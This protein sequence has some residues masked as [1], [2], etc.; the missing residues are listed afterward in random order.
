LAQSG[1]SLSAPVGEKGSSISRDQTPA[2]SAIARLGLVVE[3]SVPFSLIFPGVSMSM[4]EHHNATVIE[5]LDA[6]LL[7][8]LM[9]A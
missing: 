9:L 8:L 6:S 1:Y 7:S 4:L 5:H 3:K 2:K